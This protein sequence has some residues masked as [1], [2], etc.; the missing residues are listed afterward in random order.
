MT[1]EEA[2]KAKNKLGYT[3]YEKAGLIYFVFVTPLNNKDF[4]N[5]ITNIKTYRQAPT[6]ETA[7]LYCT[8]NEYI[9]KG[10]YYNVKGFIIWDN[11]VL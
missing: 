10:I 5:Y 4:D 1:Y 11:I 6:N 2:V 9:I 8:N 7:K 3:K